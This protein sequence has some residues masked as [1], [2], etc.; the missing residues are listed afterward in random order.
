M[1]T[2]VTINGTALSA[3]DALTAY[4][5]DFAKISDCVS[6]A[7]AYLDPKPQ[8]KPQKETAPKE[9]KTILAAKE[10]RIKVKNCKDG[11]VD[12]IKDIMPD[13]KEISVKADEENSTVIFVTFTDGTREKAILDKDDEFS[14]EHGLTIIMLEKML[15]DKGEE[16]KKEKERKIKEKIRAK[17]LKQARDEREYQIEIQKEAYL[18]A[19]R[20]IRMDD[21]K[22]S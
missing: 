14:L 11:F 10:K 17:K 13:I 16:T 15:S 18:R 22:H 9:A 1:T 2:T 20:E 21:I 4:D 3:L 6:T 19:M 7:T 8:P 5:S 12:S